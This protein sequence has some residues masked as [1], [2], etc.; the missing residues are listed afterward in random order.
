MIRFPLAVVGVVSTLAMTLPAAAGSLSFTVRGAY[1]GGG[2]TRGGH[3]T[4][5]DSGGAYLG[6][7]STRGNTTTFYSRTGSYVG[8][9][10]RTG[11][12]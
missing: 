6:S 4:F 5:T 12:R 8:S 9:V 1:A 2:I 7:S 3:T 11:R 10:T